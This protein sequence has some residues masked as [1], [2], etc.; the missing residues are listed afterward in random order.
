MGYFFP[1][2]VPFRRH[3]CKTW[4]TWLECRLTW[5]TLLEFRLTQATLLILEL[6]LLHVSVHCSS[7]TP[8]KAKVQ[9]TITNA[10]CY[11]RECLEKIIR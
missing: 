5:A 4:A 7:K 9:H 3:Y 2:S 6:R 11:I 8:K 10:T 1:Y